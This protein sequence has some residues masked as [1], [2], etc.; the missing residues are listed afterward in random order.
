MK[1]VVKHFVINIVLVIS[2]LAFQQSAYANEGIGGSSEIE[3]I[4]TKKKII[5][6]GKL[7]FK[8]DKKTTVIDRNGKHLDISVLQPGVSVR[9]DVDPARRY[10]GYPTLRSL[11]VKGSLEEHIG[12]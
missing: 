9:V 12:N 4:D 3:S 6:L 11:F 5:S 2:V 7:K 8:Y 1:A 10:V